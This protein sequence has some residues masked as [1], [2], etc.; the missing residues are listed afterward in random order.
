MPQVHSLEIKSNAALILP[1]ILEQ[2]HFRI[3]FL[4]IQALLPPM[5]KQCKSQLH[6]TG[7]YKF[8]SAVLWLGCKKCIQDALLCNTV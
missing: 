2:M 5:H 7:H 8:F 3:F 1:C 6:K 4:H